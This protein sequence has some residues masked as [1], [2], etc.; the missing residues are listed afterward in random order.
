[1]STFMNSPRFYFTS[2]SVTAGHPDKVCDQISDAIL[3]ACLEQDPNSRVA[4]ETAVKTGFAMVFGEI[5][6]AAFVN[7]DIL[8]RDVIKEIGYDSS[9]K[10]FDGNTCAVLSAISTQSADIALGVDK[11]LEAKKGTDADFSTGAGDQGMMFG[12]ACNETETLMPTPIYLAHRLVEKL[13]EVRKNGTL[14]WVYPDGKSQVTV[15]YSFGKPKRIEA[16]VIST[17]HAASMRG[18]HDEI[19]A[20]IRK[21]VIDPVLPAALVDSELKVFVNPTGEFVIGGPLGDSGL[22]GRKIIVDTYGGMGRHGGGAFSGK[23]ATKVD[24]SAAYAA[25]WV[26]KNIVAAGIADRCEIQLSYAIGVAK[27]LSINVETFGTGKIADEKIAAIVGENFDLR[28]GAI[29]E[30]LGL[31]R[32]IF[33]KTAYWGHFG[34]EDADFTWEKTD[35]AETLRKAAGL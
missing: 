29:I 26:A 21:H 7:F 30:R 8:V 18:K 15:E 5:T 6:T 2:E 35:M 3:D 24:R 14:P 32:P 23:D 31:R 4:C 12:F 13:E 10:C 1:M 27:P 20:A 16:V 11:S 33:R 28:P 19:E 17:Q 34:R 22:T 25:R 9:E